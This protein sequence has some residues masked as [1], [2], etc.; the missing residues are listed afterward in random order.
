MK[1]R[2]PQ[3]AP[4]SPTALARDWL[5]RYEHCVRQC[6]YDGAK[7]L[8]HKRTVCFGLESDLT[9]DVDAMAKAEWESLWPSQ[10]QFSFDL[11]QCS[12]IPDGGMVLV[13]I[14]WTCQSVISGAPA[15]HGRASVVLITFSNNKTLC[16]HLHMSANAKAAIA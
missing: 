13:A 14:A 10:L 9:V 7:S 4:P 1:S 16:V 6:D 11:S 8:F 2:L 12:I 5:S 15:K 3:P